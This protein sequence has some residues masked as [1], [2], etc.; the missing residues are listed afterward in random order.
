MTKGAWL[1][2]LS[3]S[4]ITSNLFPA[5][6]T[7]HTY[8]LMPSFY[9]MTIGNGS[10]AR[11]V[12]LL[13]WSYFGDNAA[14]DKGQLYDR[15]CKLA[16]EQTIRKV[17][18]EEGVTDMC[19]VTI[20]Y[21]DTQYVSKAFIGPDISRLYPWGK[22]FTNW[23]LNIQRFPEK[24]TFFRQPLEE[25]ASAGSYMYQDPVTKIHIIGIYQFE[26][27]TVQE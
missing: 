20:G 4:L 14:T 10:N 27:T 5:T 13:D 16:L 21:G 2:V 17:V 19:T 18:F 8:T 3:I 26:K 25:G 11:M 1:I 24:C 6:K 7:L 22:A 12:S 15:M 9:A 23:V